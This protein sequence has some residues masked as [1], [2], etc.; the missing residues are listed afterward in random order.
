MHLNLPCPFCKK[1]FAPDAPPVNDEIT[2]PQ[3]RRRFSIHRDGAITAPPATS[4]A[5]LPDTRRLRFTFSCSRCSS[6]LEATDDLCGRPGRCPTCGGVFRVPPI[7]PQTGLAAGRA[8]V[9][10]DGQLPTPMHAYATAGA[11]APKIIT[12]PDGQQVI[13]CPRCGRAGAVDANL[14]GACGMPFTMEGAEVII[15]TG[16][17][18]EANTLASAALTVGVLSIPTFCVPVLGVVAVVLGFLAIR[19]AETYGPGAPGRR[20]ALVGVICG[21]LSVTLCIVRYSI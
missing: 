9:E 17:G 8:L 6:V 21:L 2:C 4:T 1:S 3:C 5:Y 7:D 13:V 19:R 14:C 12:R 18:P 15:Q 10:D 20:M 11:R 16:G